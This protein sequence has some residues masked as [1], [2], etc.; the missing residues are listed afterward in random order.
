MVRPD[1]RVFDAVGLEQQLFDLL[2][3][4]GSDTIDVDL[5]SQAVGPIFDVI[6]PTEQIV[7]QF[8]RQ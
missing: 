2:E 3:R 6:V 7:F 4:A 8:G 5:P 1:D